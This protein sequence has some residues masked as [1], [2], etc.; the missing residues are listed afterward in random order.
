[1]CTCTVYYVKLP[2][3]TRELLINFPVTEC[4]RKVKKTLIIFAESNG[5]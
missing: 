4:T 5:L 3:E 2:R 1:M